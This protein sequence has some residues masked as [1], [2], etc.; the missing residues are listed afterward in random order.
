[1][2]TTTTEAAPKKPRSPFRPMKLSALDERMM[3]CQPGGY[4]WDDW[5]A[6]AL[7]AGVGDQLAWA[8]R[9]VMREAYNHD[10]PKRLQRECGWSDDGAAMLELA[11]KHPEKAKQRWEWLEATDGGRYFGNL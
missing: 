8:G 4:P 11:L 5:R 6:R 7:A 1:M 2:S 3:T 9:A 10:W